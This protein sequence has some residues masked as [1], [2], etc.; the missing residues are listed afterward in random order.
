MGRAGE[1]RIFG[2]KRRLQEFI[3]SPFLTESR[4]V[5]WKVKDGFKVFRELNESRFSE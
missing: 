4:F 1:P 2:I 5:V 3:G